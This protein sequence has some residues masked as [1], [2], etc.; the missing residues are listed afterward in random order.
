MADARDHTFGGNRLDI[1]CG[2]GPFRRKRNDADAIVR[3]LLPPAEFVQFGR[4]HPLARVRAARAV[5]R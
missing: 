4:A 2:V 3:G 5:F 1:P